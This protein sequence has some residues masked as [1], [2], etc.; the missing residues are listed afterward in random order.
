MKTWFC[1][2]LEGRDVGRTHGCMLTRAKSHRYQWTP[3]ARDAHPPASIHHSAWCPPFRIH[4]ERTLAAC[5]QSHDRDHLRALRIG[6]VLLVAT[7][8]C[9]GTAADGTRRSSRG[10]TEKRVRLMRLQIP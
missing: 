2:Q 6:I 7:S 5:R 3:L 4:C 10:V 9:D 1:V 8:M